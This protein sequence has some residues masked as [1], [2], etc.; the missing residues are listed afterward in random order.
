[1]GQVYLT[2]RLEAIPGWAE[3]GPELFDLTAEEFEARLQPY[4]GEIKG[5]L[6]RGRVVAGW[7]ISA[8]RASRAG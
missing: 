2:A 6:I 1:M 7:P 5:V 3:M 4:R 8:A